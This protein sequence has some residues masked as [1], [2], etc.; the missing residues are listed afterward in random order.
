MSIEFPTAIVVKLVEMCLLPSWA[1]CS[2]C[3]IGRRGS[4]TAAV[5]QSVGGAP[6]LS[7]SAVDQNR[8][9]KRAAHEP[10][11]GPRKP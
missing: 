3:M 4:R 1:S 6:L 9:C 5:G 10:P 7:S 8:E 2:L 11:G